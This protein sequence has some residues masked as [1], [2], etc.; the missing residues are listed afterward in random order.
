MTDREMQ[1]LADLPTPAS[2]N[3]HK[4]LVAEDDAVYRRLLQKLLQRASFEVEAVTDGI[5]ALKAAQ[6][7]DPPRLL[8]FDWIMPGLHG[9]EICRRLR[10]QPANEPYQYI[11]LLTSKDA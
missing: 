9:P 11:L 3:T 5:Q 1:G 10:S 2:L 8:I 6:A 4:V 7:P